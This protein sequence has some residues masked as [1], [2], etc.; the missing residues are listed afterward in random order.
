MLADGVEDH[1]VGLASLREVLALVVDHLVRAERAYELEGLP[2]HTAV[3]RAP[4]AFASW[5]AAV[6]IAPDAP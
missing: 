4:L 1:V 3:T 6:P 5:T 2:A